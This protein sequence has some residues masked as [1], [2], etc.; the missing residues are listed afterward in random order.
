LLKSDFV[1]NATI[2][3]LKNLIQ[4]NVQSKST[5]VTPSKTMPQRG[6][7]ASVEKTKVL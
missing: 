2:T 1:R 5:P 7:P 4:G 6:A 3:D